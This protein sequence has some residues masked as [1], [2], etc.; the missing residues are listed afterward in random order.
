MLYGC[1]SPRDALLQQR[2]DTMSPILLTRFAHPLA[3]C[4]LIGHAGAPV[5][6]YLRKARLPAQC[7]DP[8]VLVPVLNTWEF[9]QLSDR[10]EMHGIGWETGLGVGLDNL[11][12]HLAQRLRSEPTGFLALRLLVRSIRTESSNLH[13][14]VVEEDRLA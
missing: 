6:K 11:D 7:D 9:Y 13:V 1:S 12:Y 5:E 2:A 4:S 14:G 3:F 8:N 10:Q